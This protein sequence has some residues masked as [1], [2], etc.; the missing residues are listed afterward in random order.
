MVVAVRGGESMRSVAGRFAVPLSTVQ[1]WM[2]QAHGKRL[3]RVNWQDRSC[4]PKKTRRTS[5]PV[6]N[7]VLA[8]R[9]QLKEHSPLGEYGAEAI[10][11]DLQ[12][13]IHPL[14]SLRTIGRIVERHGLLDGRKR[15]RRPP[16]PSGWY[17]PDV[18]VRTCE[19]DCF[20]TIEGLAIRGGPHLSILTGISLF[21]GLAAAWP[22][23][24][25]SAKTV[26]DSLIEH[27]Q[28][29]GLPRYVQFDNDNRFTGP[30]Q[31]RNAI[32]RVI[33]MCLSLDVIPVFSVPNETGFQA[34]IESF[35]G[36]WQDKVWNRFEHARLLDLRRRSRRYI[37]AS[38]QRHATRID[39]AP[40]RTPVPKA[41]QLNLQ[42]KPRGKIIFLRRTNGSGSLEILGN[43][44]VVDQHWVHR[45]VR[46]EVD[47]D[48][49]FIQFFALRRRAPHDQP[50]LKQVHFQ[51]PNK[52]FKE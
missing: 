20:D 22:E 2:T 13:K 15:V 5:A 3:D 28:I 9:K 10:W 1:Y 32:G 26:V 19:L 37:T 44:F 50:L 43:P 41:W 27:W 18:G 4:A 7:R 23:R 48:Q 46:A 38:Q 21:G 51:L 6:E 45:L 12:G 35:N 14:P 29:W 31:Y 39:A 25:V 24:T 42:T 34:S 52:R 47:L 40:D 17:L 11:R 16:P 33:R 49:T 30:R 8:T 36:R